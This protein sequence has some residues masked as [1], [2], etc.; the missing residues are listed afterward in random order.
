[1]LVALSKCITAILPKLPELNLL[2]TTRISN[3][4]NFPRLA[5][6]YRQNFLRVYVPSCFLCETLLPHCISWPKGT[7]T[8]L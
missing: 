4:T 8:E 2:D 6:L 5:L 7:C 3:G 1:M